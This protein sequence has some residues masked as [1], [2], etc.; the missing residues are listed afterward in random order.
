MLAGLHGFL[1]HTP[2][3]S[4]RTMPEYRFEGR[5]GQPADTLLA[6]LHP[7]APGA[8]VDR[9]RHPHRVDALHGAAHQGADALDLLCRRLQDQLVVHLE[10]HPAAQLL[11]RQPAVERQMV[12]S[13][14]SL[15]RGKRSKYW[16][17]KLCAWAS[18]ISWSRASLC[19]PIP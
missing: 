15:T 18:V 13:M 17:M 3:G 8:Q 2:P 6:R 4:E 1:A 16:R 7:V 9:Q 12:S 11:L 5:S 19:A 10:D 14:Y